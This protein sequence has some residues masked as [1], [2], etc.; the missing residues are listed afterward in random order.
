[1]VVWK[2]TRA[3]LVSNGVVLHEMPLPKA[4]LISGATALAMGIYCSSVAFAAH[5]PTRPFDVQS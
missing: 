2:Y 5:S 1:M 3:L 4:D